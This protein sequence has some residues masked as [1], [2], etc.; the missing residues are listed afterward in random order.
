M[1]M[2]EVVAYV[3]LQSSGLHMEIPTIVAVTTSER[4]ATSWCNITKNRRAYENMAHGVKYWPAWAH[5]HGVREEVADG[6]PIVYTTN[7]LRKYAKQKL[8]EIGWGDRWYAVTHL[9]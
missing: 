7:R 4:K 6:F 8:A 5:G 2:E 9:S 3:L 1:I